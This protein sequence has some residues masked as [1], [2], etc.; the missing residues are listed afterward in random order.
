[1]PKPPKSELVPPIYGRKRPFMP[2]PIERL[3]LDSDNPRLP[4]EIQGRPEPEL[5]QYLYDHFALE[6]IAGP[7]AENGYF[8]EEPLVAIPD[9]LPKRLLPKAGEGISPEFI[10]FLRTAEFTIVTKRRHI[11][12]AATNNRGGWKQAKIA[13]SCRNACTSTSCASKNPH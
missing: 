1:M 13:T 12:W 9:N 11:L 8:D 4:E 5:L 10:E 3:H 7:M 2:V 6:E